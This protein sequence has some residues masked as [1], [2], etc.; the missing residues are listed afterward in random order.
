M[1]IFERA[2]LQTGGTRRTVGQGNDNQRSWYQNEDIH[3]RLNLVLEVVW[4]FCDRYTGRRRPV[5]L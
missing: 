5:D 1:M 3:H 4:Y 2:S